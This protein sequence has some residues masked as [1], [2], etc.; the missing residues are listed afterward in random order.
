MLAFGDQGL[1]LLLLRD[2]ENRVHLFRNGNQQRE[3]TSAHT[4]KDSLLLVKR[5][6]RGQKVRTRE[7]I[8]A[9]V[10]KDLNGLTVNIWT[11]PAA[12]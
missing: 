7:M 4:S 1:L 5:K 8:D 2:Y 12:A 6:I 10:G 3:L 11:L 9:L